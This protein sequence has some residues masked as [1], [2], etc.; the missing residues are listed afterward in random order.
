M[1]WLTMTSLKPEQSFSWIIYPNLVQ[2]QINMWNSFH[3]HQ[4]RNVTL[5]IATIKT[6][7][8][9]WIESVI[10]LAVLLISVNMIPMAY[11]PPGLCYF[12][13]GDVLLYLPLIYLISKKNWGLRMAITINIVNNQYLRPFV[14]EERSF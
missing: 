10:L 9:L 7:A 6:C 8:I 13:I 14:R 11:Y 2:R 1:W 5:K 4:E 12:T 3:C